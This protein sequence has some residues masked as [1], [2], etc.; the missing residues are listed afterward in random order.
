MRIK[1]CSGVLTYARV[2][3]APIHGATKPDTTKYGKFLSPPSRAG[4]GVCKPGGEI[5][6]PVLRAHWSF[7]HP[8]LEG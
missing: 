4:L 3:G 1:H 6:H 7:G 2:S 8:S 5:T